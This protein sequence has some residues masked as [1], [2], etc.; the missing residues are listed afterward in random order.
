M[1]GNGGD[2][3][4]FVSPA[5]PSTAGSKASARRTNAESTGTSAVRRKISRGGMRRAII[6][7]SGD[8]HSVPSK[9]GPNRATISSPVQV[10]IR[11]QD[12]IASIEK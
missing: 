10:L 8:A 6:A 12:A 1:P 5:A 4:T 11:L 7:Y 9:H 2:R 3:G